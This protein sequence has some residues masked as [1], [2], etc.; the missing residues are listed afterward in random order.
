MKLCGNISEFSS[1]FLI[2]II[3]IV[4]A[5]NNPSYSSNDVDLLFPWHIV[6]P[7]LASQIT[8]HKAKKACDGSYYDLDK[9][10]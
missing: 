4:N 6:K 10:I 5:D 1:F 9:Y 2:L 8:T 7:D 3:H